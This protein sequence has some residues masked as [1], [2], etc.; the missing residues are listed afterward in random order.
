MVRVGDC[1]VLLLL[2]LF[3]WFFGWIGCFVVLVVSLVLCC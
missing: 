1:L 3:W 2:V